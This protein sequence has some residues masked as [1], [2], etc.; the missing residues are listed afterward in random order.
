MTRK[1][2]SDGV[3]LLNGVCPYYTM[4]PISFP[5]ER[6]REASSGE[7]VIDPFC[8]R[9]STNYAARLLG[10][11][12]LGIDSNPV[13]AAIAQ[14]K[15]VSTTPGRIVQA[16]KRIL[17]TTPAP[18]LPKGEFWDNCYH[19]HTLRQLVKL[20][21]ALRTNCS[22]P[23]RQALRALLLG[24]LHGPLLKSSLQS[25]LSNQ[26]PRTYAAKPSYAIKFWRQHKMKP[27]EVDVLELVARKAPQYF[28]ELPPTVTGAVICADSSS[29]E[30]DGIVD[31]AR[32]VVTSPPYYG[33]RT[34]IPDQWLRYWFVGG[35]PQVS[36][37]FKGQLEH[38][39]PAKFAADLGRVWKNM[40]G[41]CAE[42]ARMVIRFGGIRDRNQS[43]REIIWESI[44]LADCAWK[45]T[46]VKSAG[47]A[48]NGKRQA[49]QFLSQLKEPVAEFDVYAR[50]QA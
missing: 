19:P 22:T 38:T 29:I 14:A 8:G 31:K 46:T 32:W 49:K 21:K 30:L 5:L 3:L 20:R 6:L 1:A 48:T 41:A 40:A 9:G 24:R 37:R 18:R 4:F 43:P 42:G 45:I 26:M 23:A 12:S 36:Y 11:P 50:L 2:P 7:W 44:R 33:M 15:V 10:L 34:Y 47:L 27:P 28:G 35:P 16:C 25:Y 17:E 39:S 13:A